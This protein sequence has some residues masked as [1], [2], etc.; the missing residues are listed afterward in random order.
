MNDANRRHLLLAALGSGAGLLLPPARGQSGPDFESLF[1]RALA[2]PASLEA[3]RSLRERPPMLQA[4]PPGARAVRSDRRIAPEAVRLI[5]LFEV[6]SE[7]V[8][9]ARYEAPAWPG[10]NSGTTI[11]VGYDLGYTNRLWLQ[12]DW[13][14]YLSQDAMKRLQATCGKHGTDAEALIRG[15]RDILVPWDAAYAQFRD[16]AL[17]LYIGE[18]LKALPLA[19]DLSDKSLGALV[20]LVYNRGTS[21]SNPPDAYSKQNG[22]KDRYFEMRA[23][24]A[25]LAS[26]QVALIPGL[27]GDMTRL[28]P[29]FPGLVRRRELEAKLF[30]EGLADARPPAAASKLAW[31]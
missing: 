28:W 26:G 16:H 6:T 30:E 4:L 27:I 7:Q 15:L 18:T 20:S 10:G 11:G 29:K 19:K 3:A 5:V 23:I 25:A 13:G 14:S 17:P 22:L 24:K 1:A 8:Y 12:E 31:Q 9:T 21:F 2:D